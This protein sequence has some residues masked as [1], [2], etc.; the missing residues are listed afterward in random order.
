[1]GGQV[2]LIFTNS[3]DLTVDRLIR[4]IGP[5][6]VFRFNFDLWRD[7]RISIS[8]GDFS[9]TNPVGREV[10]RSDVAKFYWRKPL[11]KYRLEWTRDV[12]TEVLYL[13][14]EMLYAIREIKNL[15]WRDGKVVLIEP[16]AHQRVGK[17]VQMEIAEKYFQV[18]AYQFSYDPK[19]QY[20]TGKVRI[21]K[22]LSSERITDI[23]FLW[24]TRVKENDLDPATPW[25]VQDLV[26]AT[27]DVTTVF[28]RDKMFSFSLDRSAFVQQTVDWRE[29]GPETTPFWKPHVMP[30]ELENSIAAYMQDLNLHYGR[31]DFLLDGNTYWFLE[32]N[33]NGEWDW[34]DPRG[35]GGLLTKMV[36]ELH[37]DSPVHPISIQP[38]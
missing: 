17:L 12:P 10:R 6:Q 31:L 34:L 26:E 15:L 9:I 33:T 20:R 3:F 14:E 36:E 25:L 23:T 4:H 22:S 21:V 16:A 19:R 13:E 24:T 18:P 8:A 38:S 32:V 7:Y 5:D 30:Q 27:L 1:M 28:V 11:S 29:V 2:T 37:P 35:D